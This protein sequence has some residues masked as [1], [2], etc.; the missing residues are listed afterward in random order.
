MPRPRVPRRRAPRGPGGPARGHRPPPPRAQPGSGAI[1]PA[2]SPRE[3]HADVLVPGA[4]PTGLLDEPS[5]HEPP[6]GLAIS[7]MHDYLGLLEF[8]EVE[9]EGT[10]EGA[11]RRSRLIELQAQ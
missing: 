4:L 5:P 8:V 1:D 10:A 6:H 7:G 3:Q 11:V 9:L 2:G